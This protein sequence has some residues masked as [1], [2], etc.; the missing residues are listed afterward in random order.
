MPQFRFRVLTSDG[1]V[2]S[3]RYTGTSLEAARQQIE[4][5]GLKVLELTP[6]EEAE[7]TPVAVPRKSHWWERVS[8]YWVAAALAAWGLSW[9]LLRWSL[10]SPPPPKPA[11]DAV[12]MANQKFQAEFRA[13]KV[14][15]APAEGTTLI[16]RFPEI[17]YQVE[18]SWPQGTTQIEF[19]AARQPSFCIVELR[20]KKKVLATARIQ[21][22]LSTNEFLMTG[23]PP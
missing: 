16:F 4:K 7:S 23:T 19:L 21:P 3:G 13:Q 9:G 11:R 10:P 18:R 1:R 14:G 6:L 2:R 15:S 22:L 17:P 20:D 5:S 12:A 8:G